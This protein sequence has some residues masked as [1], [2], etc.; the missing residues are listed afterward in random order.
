MAYLCVIFTIWMVWNVLPQL[1]T[2]PFWFPYILAVALG[3]GGAALVDADH[4]WW[5]IGLAGMAGFLLT[6]S[7]LALVTT[8]GIRARVVARGPVRR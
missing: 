3:V 1:L 4:W 8:D 5:G 2:T 6:L 7:D